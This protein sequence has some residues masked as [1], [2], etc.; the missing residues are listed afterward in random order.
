MEDDNKIKFSWM[1]VDEEEEIMVLRSV[2][3]YLAVDTP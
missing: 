3:K 1:L 2:R